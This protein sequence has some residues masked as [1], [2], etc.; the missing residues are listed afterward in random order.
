MEQLQYFLVF[1]SAGVATAA[2]AFIPR[3]IVLTAAIATGLWSWIAVTPTIEQHKGVCCTYTMDAGIY[4]YLGGGM[5]LISLG[6]LVL[7]YFG[8]YPP[9][10]GLSDDINDSGIMPGD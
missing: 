7:F 6:A 9:D 8:L 2:W 1:G 5:A 3:R 4:Q 10:E